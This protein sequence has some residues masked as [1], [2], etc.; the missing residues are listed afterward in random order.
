MAESERA[1]RAFEAYRDALNITGANV[2]PTW[3]QLPPSMREAWAMAVEAVA[4]RDGIRASLN[5]HANDNMP[6]ERVAR[7]MFAETAAMDFNTPQRLATHWAADGRTRGE[8]YD[9]AGRA[10]RAL[11]RINLGQRRWTEWENDLGNAKDG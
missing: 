6:Q 5:W 10:M 9:W 7:E 1:Q 3:E 8:F 2:R 4:D 11:V